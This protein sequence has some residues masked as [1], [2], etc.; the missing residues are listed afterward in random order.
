MGWKNLLSVIGSLTDTFW[1]VPPYLQATETCTKD[2]W[3]AEALEPLHA[4]L[5]GT[6]QSG[7][8]SAS[9]RGCP[10]KGGRSIPKRA[11][12]LRLVSR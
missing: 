11:R 7:G 3:T 10:D 12:S 5:H 9:W 6:V 8:A 4:H 1:K 2:M